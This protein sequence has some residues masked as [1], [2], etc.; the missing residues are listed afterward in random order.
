MLIL[1][2]CSRHEAPSIATIRSG[3]VDNLINEI[4]SSILIRKSMILKVLVSIYILCFGT[5]KESISLA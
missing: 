5:L 4:K 2:P 3:D 1:S